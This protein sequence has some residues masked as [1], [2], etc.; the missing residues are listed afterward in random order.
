MSLRCAVRCFA[1]TLAMSACA[2]RPPDPTV[3]D[4]DKYRVVVDNP[5][6]RVLRYHDEPGARTALHHH[7]GFV[8]IPLSA[9]RRRLTFADGSTKQ[10][11]FAPGEAE[12]MRAQSHQGEN[13]GDTPTDV[14]LVEPKRS[15]P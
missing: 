9:F 7:P 2:H 3:T 1:V 12:W 8:M 14:L 6:V 11:S 15:C 5:C 4:G 10:R 13:V